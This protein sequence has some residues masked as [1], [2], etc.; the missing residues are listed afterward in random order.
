MLGSAGSPV[1]YKTR[2]SRNRRDGVCTVKD[3]RWLILSNISLCSWRR[4]G[5]HTYASL[6]G[7]TEKS[8]AFDMQKCGRK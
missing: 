3:G 5:T 1:G 2:D 4:G 6:G 7:E 8:V